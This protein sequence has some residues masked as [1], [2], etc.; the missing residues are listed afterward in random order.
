VARAVTNVTTAIPV[1]VVLGGDPVEQGFVATLARPGGNITG[2]STSMAE[3]VP[4]QLELLKE[5][6]PKVSSVAL[7]Q[8]PD[9]SARSTVR[10]RRLSA[11][12]TRGWSP[13]TRAACTKAG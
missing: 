6:V 13:R 5:A 11:T 8:N 4:K 3:I 7:L 10:G 9:T 2:L 12:A 1:I